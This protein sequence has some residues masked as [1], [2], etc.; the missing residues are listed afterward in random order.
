[1]TRLT[2]MSL[3]AMFVAAAALTVAAAE[4]TIPDTPAGRCASALIKAFNVG[5][6]TPIR[7]FEMEHR[8]K[9]MARRRSLD[10]RVA[11]WR[12]RFAD[13]G[14]LEARNVLSSGGYD[15]LVV[16]EPEKGEG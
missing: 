15:I 3:A 13:W 1:M 6:D 11:G 8:A 14:K 5:N 10:D 12:N 16:V 2:S 9:A 4:N 7:Q